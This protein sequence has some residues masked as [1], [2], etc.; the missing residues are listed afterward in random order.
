[1][2]KL[3]QFLEVADV[4]ETRK[5]LSKFENLKWLIQNLGIRNGRLDGFAEANA[6]LK[7]LFKSKM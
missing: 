1:M 3:E 2:T 5:D 6:E 7:Q 4:P